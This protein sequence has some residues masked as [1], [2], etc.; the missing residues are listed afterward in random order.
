[1]TAWVR[2]YTEGGMWASWRELETEE[3]PADQLL[4]APAEGTQEKATEA[5]GG[6]GALWGHGSLGVLLGFLLPR[7]FGTEPHGKDEGGLCSCK[8]LLRHQ[9][10]LHSQLSLLSPLLPLCCPLQS[11]N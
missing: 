5:L 3:V 2:G 7:T 4:L 8:L 6:S 1:M 9:V 11:Q 10:L